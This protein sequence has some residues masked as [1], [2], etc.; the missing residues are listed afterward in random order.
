MEWE[1]NLFCLWRVLRESK[2]NESVIKSSFFFFF[3]HWKPTFKA[4]IS[5]ILTFLHFKPRSSSR[6]Q[7]LSP[8]PKAGLFAGGHPSLSL[9][10]ETRLF[11][12][13]RSAPLWLQH[14]HTL[15]DLSL[16]HCCFSP[17]FHGNTTAA[18]LPLQSSFSES[19]I[20][21]ALKK[22]EINVCVPSRALSLQS[23]GSFSSQGEERI[24]E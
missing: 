1:I 14:S 15:M 2:W 19:V 13:R 17:S 5:I 3:C 4:T 7:H 21:I 10:L 6:S 8:D 16:G 18:S 11:D 20:S 12:G 9:C 23:W 22:R 24:F